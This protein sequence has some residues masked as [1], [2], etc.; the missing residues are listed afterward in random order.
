MQ[1]TLQT[2]GFTS[3]TAI[4]AFRIGWL[5]GRNAFQCFSVA[6]ILADSI[7]IVITVKTGSNDRRATKNDPKT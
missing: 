4:N 2:G 1:L 6:N 3:H 7:Q 5:T